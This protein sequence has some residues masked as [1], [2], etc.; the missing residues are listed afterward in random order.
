MEIVK[1]QRYQSQYIKHNLHNQ[2]VDGKAVLAKIAIQKK[3]KVTTRSNE[4]LRKH[5]AKTRQRK[6]RRLEGN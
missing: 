1:D 4:D 5:K 2:A 6:P 3:N